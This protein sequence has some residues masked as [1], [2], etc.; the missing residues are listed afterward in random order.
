LARSSRARRM[1]LVLRVICLPPLPPPSRFWML[2]PFCRAG[3]EG[4]RN[5]RFFGHLPVAIAGKLSVTCGLGYKK[6]PG[7]SEPVACASRCQRGE[8]IGGGC[9]SATGRQTTSSQMPGFDSL[10][11]RAKSDSRGGRFLA[12]LARRRSIF[13]LQEHTYLCQRIG[14]QVGRSAP[15]NLGST[16]A[17]VHTLH[18]IA[19]NCAG[20]RKIRGKC[21]FERIRFR[22]VCYWT[23]QCQP[24]LAIIVAG[25]NDQ[26]G[27]PASLLVTGLG[28]EIQPD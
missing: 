1:G 3:G 10:N 8:L 6:G 22:L 25:R 5:G 13:P 11:R 18:M 7:S 2:R 21:H 15:D 24:G 23:N 20:N 17:P 4:R 28:G 27:P 19:Q 14:K 16:G 9:G 12:L 26:G